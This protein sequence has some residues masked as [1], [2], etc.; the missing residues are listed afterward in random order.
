MKKSDVAK[1]LGRRVNSFRVARGYT[2][3]QLGERCGFT[4]K[5]VSEIERGRVNVPLLTLTKIAGSLGT[6]LSELT[7]GVDT[8]AAT[9]ARE[10][11]GLYSTR[12]RAEQA[13]VNKLMGAIEDLLREAKL[14]GDPD[15]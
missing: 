7:F 8:A 14:G 13:A 6:T 15:R 5:F 3:E 12:S 1:R 10:S 11:P 9:S 2:Q 4:S